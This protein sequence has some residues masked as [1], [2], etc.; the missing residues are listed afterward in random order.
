MLR[1]VAVAA[2]AAC[3]APLHTV[4][5]VNKTDRVIEEVYVYPAGA[6][7]HGTSRGQLAPNAT[8]D[9]KVRAGNVDV[10]AVS[11]KVQID[12]KTRERRTASQTLQL[13]GPVQL[14]FHDSDKTPPGLNAPNVFGVSF[15]VE[16]PPEPPE[17]PPE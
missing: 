1:F 14:V 5:L 13:K 12:D 10:L 3:S 4:T 6:S 7:N 16:K 9:Y 15:R 2:L 11:A 8:V 17:P